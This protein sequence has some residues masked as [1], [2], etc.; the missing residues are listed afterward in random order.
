MDMSLSK[1][2]EIVKDR[3][4]WRAAVHGVT[5]SQTRLSNWVTTTYDNRWWPIQW[6]NWEAAPNYFPKPS[7]QQKDIMV[8]VSWSAAHL[9]HYSFLKPLHLG[10]M[11]IKSMRCT[12]NC[13]A[14]SWHW[15]AERTQFFSMTVAN[16][17]LH[18][19]CFQS[20][21][22]RAMKFCLIL[23]IHLTSHQLTTTS[24]SISTIFYRENAST[25]SRR[26]KMLS[27]SS[28]H[29]KAQIFML[30]E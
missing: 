11:L 24:S 25:T 1:L 13:N 30:Q 6:L 16:C 9:I 29:P 22:N 10:S 27:K 28:S 8:T 4:A 2:W 17:M 15:S 26:Q 14:C 7:L 12:K 5:H 19:Q 3:E 23:Y 18:N 21:M 20:W